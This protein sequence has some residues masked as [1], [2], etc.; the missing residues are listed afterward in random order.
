MSTVTTLM[1]D[2]ADAIQSECPSVAL[3]AP[4]IDK[5]FATRW[6]SENVK[7]TVLGITPEGFQIRNMVV[8]S[9][10][11]F[12]HDESRGRRRVA[13]LGPTVVQSLFLGDDPHRPHVSS[14]TRSV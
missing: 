8:A 13:I 11:I 3:A 14:R 10:R 7:T 2:D 9:G 12:D 6:E 5:K 4:A 1:V